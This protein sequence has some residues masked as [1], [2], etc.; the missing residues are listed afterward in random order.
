VGKV[1]ITDCTKGDSVNPCTD[2]VCVGIPP[3]NPGDCNPS[4]K[5]CIATSANPGKACTVATETS[6]CSG[7]AIDQA[8]CTASAACARMGDQTNGTYGC[9]TIFNPVGAPIG[10]FDPVAVG[11]ARTSGPP[12]LASG[13][14]AC[15][16]NNTCVDQAQLTA[17][18]CTVTTPTD[19]LGQIVD[20]VTR[21]LT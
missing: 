5:K 12:P 1:S 13:P 19:Q 16:T 10:S 2:G 11:P 9:L 3:G 7:V 6:D 21:S 18:S 4:T 17:A 8:T 15:P 14:G 20:G